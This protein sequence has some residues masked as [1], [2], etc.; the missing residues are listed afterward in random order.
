MVAP[1]FK[2]A[3]SE[4]RRH[5][6]TSLYFLAVF[7]LTSL[8]A[9]AALRFDEWRLVGPGSAA[10]MLA[11]SIDP[12]NDRNII[13]AASTSANFIS[14]DGTR[15]GA[16]GHKDDFGG[17]IFQ[18]HDLFW[19]RSPLKYVANVRTPTLILHSDNDCR[20][21]I[22]QGSQ[23]FRA[24]KPFRK[25]VDYLFLPCGQ[26]HMPH[27]GAP[28]PGDRLLVEAIG[29]V[30][31]GSQQS[32]LSSGVHTVVGTPGRLLDLIRQAKLRTAPLPFLVLH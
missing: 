26:H 22:E 5:P 18:R 19:D 24:P 2:N 12:H 21:P 31:V 27:A 7:V 20:V 25:T 29:G 15:D 28:K 4:S 11:M 32:A 3:L 23:W 16:Y 6:R 17:D 14:D 10:P 30:A 13:L 1:R 8:F 9:A